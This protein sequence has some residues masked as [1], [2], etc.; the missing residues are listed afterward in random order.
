MNAEAPFPSDNI[1]MQ[2]STANVFGTGRASPRDAISGE[3][4]AG[5]NGIGTCNNADFEDQVRFNSDDEKKELASLSVTDAINVQNDLYGM[6]TDVTSL[7]LR[8][9]DLA[10][11]TT[12]Q[13]ADG[14]PISESLSK[15]ASNTATHCYDSTTTIPHLENEISTLPTSDTAAYRQAQQ[16]CPDQLSDERK[17]AFVEY[18]DGNI[19]NAARKLVKYWSERLDAFGPERAFLPM[20]LAGTMQDEVMDWVQRP[21]W[22]LLPATDSAGRSILFAQT[23]L[24]DFSQYTTEQELRSFMY[25]LETLMEDDARRRKGFIVLYDGRDL[26]RK[27]FSKA[28]SSKLASLTENVYPIDCKAIH[29]CIPARSSTSSLCPS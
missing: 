10:S 1:L 4:S 22:Q 7:G 19:A 11:V 6:V 29:N 17:M 24:R 20:T 18:E 5:S 12:Q 14:R 2:R 25:L 27:H 21:I 3:S 16:R 28:L 23:S 26:Q 15:T 8:A 9:K 13:P